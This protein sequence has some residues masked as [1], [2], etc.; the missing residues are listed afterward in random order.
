MAEK[1]A[2]RINGETTWEAMS[3]T[4]I[5]EVKNGCESYLGVRV[6]S[7]GNWE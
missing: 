6:G 7:H 2:G 4:E 5:T 1:S 3:E